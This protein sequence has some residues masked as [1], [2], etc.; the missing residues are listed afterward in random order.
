MGGGKDKTLNYELL[1]DL[2]RFI[3]LFYH[4]IDS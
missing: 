4:T 1:V 3:T 2:S